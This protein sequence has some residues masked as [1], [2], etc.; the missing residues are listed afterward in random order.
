MAR[1]SRRR[2]SPEVARPTG[3]WVIPLWI[4]GTMVA[5][6]LE[7][8]WFPRAWDEAGQLASRFYF[9]DARAYLS[10]A[11]ALVDGETFDNGVPFHPPGWPFV[12]S[13]V[14]RA[15]GG[16]SDSPPDPLTI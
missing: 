16:F 12:L 3:R 15:L 14:F 2:G 1:R 7:R 8:W 9:G 5:A 4:A 13:A 11:V 6:T 10:Y